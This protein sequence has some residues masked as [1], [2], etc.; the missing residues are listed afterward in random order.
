MH[1]N[2]II[3]TMFI[4]IIANMNIIVNIGLKIGIEIAIP[5]FIIEYNIK[6]IYESL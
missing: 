6:P 1:L 3:A 2:V 5:R 4:I